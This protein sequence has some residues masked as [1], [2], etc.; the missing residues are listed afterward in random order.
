[1]RVDIGDMVDPDLFWVAPAR[2]SGRERLRRLEN[3]LA[4]FYNGQ[5]LSDRDCYTPAILAE[6][7]KVAVMSSRKYGLWQ[8]AK[9]TSFAQY[10]AATAAVTKGCQR[11]VRPVGEQSRADLFL[12]DAGLTLKGVDVKERV[13]LL[14]TED[15]DGVLKVEEAAFLVKLEGLLPIKRS[16][17]FD[18][19]TEDDH[20]R[21]AVSR[22]WNEV[23]VR[24]CRALSK[25]ALSACFMANAGGGE[26]GVQVKG[27]HAIRVGQLT[28]ELPLMLADNR[29]RPFTAYVTSGM[30]LNG[31][32]RFLDL[33]NCL[34]DSGFAV[35]GCRDE[36]LSPGPAVQSNVQPVLTLLQER[37][38]TSDYQSFEVQQQQHPPSF[39]H[40]D[41][42]WKSGSL[43]NAGNRNNKTQ[44]KAKMENLRRIKT[45]IDDSSTS[46]GHGNDDVT[47]NE[48]TTD[49]NS[50]VKFDEEEESGDNMEIIDG[51]KFYDCRD[52]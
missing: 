46:A 43:E 49:E 44:K 39:W 8:R 4:D 47:G 29:L 16:I 26:V 10:S 5:S 41:F 13:R 34:V 17:D 24:M 3:H 38:A 35:Q 30:W 18:F 7:Q 31:E 9:V 14:P 48:E 32:R 52:C 15:E 33:N 42:S 12:V 20:F 25:T 21:N 51:E 2:G 28:L 36:I 1:M 40:N 37:H 45:L 27:G 19:F 11:F 50:D 6:G 23:C 22:Q